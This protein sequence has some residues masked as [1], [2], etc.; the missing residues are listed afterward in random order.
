MNQLVW[1]LALLAALASSAQG[2]TVIP[3]PQNVLM[4]S[5]RATVEVPMDW[6]SVAMSTTR[7][8]PD[9]AVV[10]SQLKSALD[11]ALG[12]ARK[13]AKPGQVEVRTGAFSIYP[14]YAPKGGIAGW[15]GTTELIIEGRDTAAISQL[16]GKLQTLTVA[17]VN[18]SLSREAREKVESDVA[19][20]AIARFR[21]QADAYAKQF[22]FAGYTIREV[23]V[24]TGGEGPQPVPMMRAQMAPAMAD[25]ALP[26]EAGRANVTA[27][28]GGSVQM[29][30]R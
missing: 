13:V 18:F 16:T 9:A 6:L 24:N 21:A 2:Q 23:N 17:R 14:R 15:Q 12:E 22:G 5:A 3:P 11:A 19:A 26:V 27:T 28:V 8:A 20:Q 10:Q 30:I 25:A 7:E 29:S 4:L 1:G